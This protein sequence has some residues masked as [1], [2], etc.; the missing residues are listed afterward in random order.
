MARRTTFALALILG[1]GFGNGVDLNNSGEG[2]R[3]Q[4]AGWLHNIGSGD[5]EGLFQL[6]RQAWKR[7]QD[8]GEEEVPWSRSPPAEG[9][10]EEAKRR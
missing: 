5:P 8:I 2:G 3:R 9:A 6:L 4:V 10:P 1:L 7:R